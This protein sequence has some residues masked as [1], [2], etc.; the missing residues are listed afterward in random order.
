M[1]QLNMHMTKTFEDELNMLMTLRHISTKSEAIR[2]A[3]RE[4]LQQLTRKKTP[5]DF[6]S[7]RGSALPTQKRK[8]KIV[9]SDDEMW[10][11]HDH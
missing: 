4:N 5:T 2:I 10:E 8:N 9:L 3:V 7:W 6:A 1:S 11:K